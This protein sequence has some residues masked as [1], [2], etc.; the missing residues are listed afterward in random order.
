V[1]G[2]LDAAQRIVD[3]RSSSEAG[4]SAAIEIVEN[5]ELIVASRTRRIQSKRVGPSFRLNTFLIRSSDVMGQGYHI[6][7]ASIAHIPAQT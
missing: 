6:Q 3:G 1:D 4:V 2:I 5:A 7:H